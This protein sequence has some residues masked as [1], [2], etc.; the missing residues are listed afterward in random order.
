MTLKINSS[1][2]YN[3]A[4]EFYHTN[5]VYD[6]IEKLA[7]DNFE[8]IEILTIGHT[9]KGT[10]LKIIRIIPE[11][12]NED[13][14][15]IWVDGGTHA[16]EWITVS[17]VLYVLDVFVNNRNSLSVTMK[18]TEFFLMPIL[19]P[20]GYMYSHKKDRLWRKNLAGTSHKH[21]LGIDL[22]R[23]W[24]Y[25]WYGLSSNR[26]P[27]SET[28]RGSHPS[29]E[30]EVKAI[31]RF[32]E[33]NRYKI[34]GFITFHSYGQLILYPWAYTKSKLQDQAD[35]HTVGQ[36]ISREILNKT[37]TEYKVGSA[38]TAIDWAKGKALI[39]YVY[40]VELGDTGKNGFLLQKNQIIPNGQN[41]FCVISVVAEHIKVT[42]PSIS[43]TKFQE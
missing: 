16:R 27:C 28:Y 8:L 26:D 20:D 24:D 21:C 19:N 15:S 1:D 3:I 30:F 9:I 41:A 10:P 18:N 40:A 29:S 7:K 5:L 11:E 32:I 31:S 38:R 35:L 2:K 37:S 36:M 34:K 23:N 17:S 43:S 25:E 14:H 12:E 39:K 33:E 42:D 4:L 13:Y 6:I 22:N